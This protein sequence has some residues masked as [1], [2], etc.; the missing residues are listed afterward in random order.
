MWMRHDSYDARMAPP[1]GL[2]APS[3]VASSPHP[4]A[5]PPSILPS[6]YL[7]HTFH[8]S[9]Y[10]RSP[11]EP[12]TGSTNQLLRQCS[13]LCPTYCF[14]SAI[15][16]ASFPILSPL[17]QLVPP[18]ALR[19]CPFPLPTPTSPQGPAG[20][21]SPT[22]WTAGSFSRCLPPCC[23]D[24]S[25]EGFRRWSWETACACRLIRSGHVYQGRMAAPWTW[26]RIAGDLL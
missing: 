11:L 16:S 24:Q 3:L 10:P 23:F 1:N 18:S 12:T 21:S 20:S 7:E 15:L 4:T 9:L 2:T 19:R 13:C 8:F 6:L 25:P 26:S 17:D 22:Q 5:L 14:T